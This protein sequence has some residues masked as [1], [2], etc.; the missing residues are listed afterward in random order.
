MSKSTKLTLRR[1]ECP[2]AFGLDLFGDKWTLLILRDLLFYNVTR[3]SD[4]AVREKIAPNILA[5]RLNRL[6]NAGLITKEQ[7]KVLK[8][9]NVYHIT[10]KGHELLPVL[11]EMMAWGLRNDEQ[12]PVS[13]QFLHRLDEERKQVVDEVI[14]ATENGTIEDYRSKE[15]GVDPN[16]YINH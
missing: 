10:D 6:E 5:D 4:F 14:N 12:A 8:N 1:S 15:M 13:E 16:V 2:I 11:A 9:Q 3:F 7:D